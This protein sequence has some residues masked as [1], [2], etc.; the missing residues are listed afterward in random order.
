MI[1]PTSAGPWKRGP[2]FLSVADTVRSNAF[3]VIVLVVC[4]AILVG[5]KACMDTIR[6][7]HDFDREL[8][9]QRDDMRALKIRQECSQRWALRG[10]NYNACVGDE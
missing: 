9:Q 6:A 10:E 2:V 1:P 8:Q 7:A 4:A 3:T 5:T